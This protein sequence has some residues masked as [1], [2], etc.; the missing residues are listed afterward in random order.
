MIYN[1]PFHCHGFFDLFFSLTFSFS[2]SA[3]RSTLRSPVLCV[4]IKTSRLK[5]PPM[6]S[7]CMALR[8]F[9]PLSGSYWSTWRAKV[10]AP[11]TYTSSCCAAALHSQEVSFNPLI[12]VEGGVNKV[13]KKELQELQQGLYQPHQNKIEKSL[14]VF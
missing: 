9:D 1:C 14:S 7:A 6:G 13:K 3:S 10:F 4:S 2:F 12:N 8:H 11:T 5:W